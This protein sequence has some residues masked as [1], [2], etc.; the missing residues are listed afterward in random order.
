M[1]RRTGSQ[2][3]HE[4]PSAPSIASTSGGNNSHKLTGIA[5]HELLV[6]RPSSQ[7]AATPGITASTAAATA[8]NKLRKSSPSSPSGQFLTGSI[9][10][11]VSC[12]TAAR[13]AQASAIQAAAK[14][15]S[16]ISP[17]MPATASAIVPVAKTPIKIARVHHASANTTA[18]PIDII[19]HRVSTPGEN[20]NSTTPTSNSR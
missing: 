10:S 11:A 1:L 20:K 16:N 2:L 14:I 6:S 8:R 7:L 13:F 18:N 5:N 12:S 19:N 9:S 3:T 4:S 17:N 15:I